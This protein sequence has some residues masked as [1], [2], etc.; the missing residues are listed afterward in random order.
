V[1]AIP[2][3]GVAFLAAFVK[4]AIGV[5]FPTRGTPLLSLVT[6]VKTAV[7]VL[8][9]PNIVMDGLQF[10]RRGAPIASSDAAVLLVFGGVG[11]VIRHSDADRALRMHGHPGHCHVH[12]RIR[13]PRRE[14]CHIAYLSSDGGMGIADCRVSWPASSAESRSAGHSLLFYVHALGLEKHA[15]VSSVALHS[16]TRSSSLAR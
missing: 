16:S 6:D 14:R 5:G 11:T 12:P 7:V 3:T 2:A 1:T 9:I 4:G 13:A 15:F 10:W 8:I